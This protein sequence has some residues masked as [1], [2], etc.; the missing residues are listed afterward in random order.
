MKNFNVKKSTISNFVS[1]YVVNNEMEMAPAAQYIF[2]GFDNWT[3]FRRTAKI[4]KWIT[5]L[6]Y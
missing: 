3:N 4:F 5:R 6:L 1:A 2:L